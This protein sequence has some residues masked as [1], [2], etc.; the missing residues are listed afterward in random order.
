MT[1]LR[2]ALWRQEER[3]RSVTLVWVPG[4]CGVLGNE[5]ADRLSAEGST[6][7]QEDISINGSTR[8]ALIRREVRGSP[9]RHERLREVYTSELREA[10]EAQLNRA[11]RVNFTRF[12]T[13]HHSSLGRWRTM[14]GQTEEPTCLHYQLGE[15]GPEHLWRESTA[16][17]GLRRQHQLIRSMASWWSTTAGVGDAQDHPELPR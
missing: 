4:H 3:G 17:E 8:R 11:D 16:L 9:V 2:R 10:E 14:V 6:H 13:G 15:E 7:Q 5:E 12:R 1:S